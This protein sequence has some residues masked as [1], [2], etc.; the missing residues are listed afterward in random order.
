MRV[1][2]LILAA[3]LAIAGLVAAS[4]GGGG[5]D[6]TSMGGMDMSGATP[7]MASGADGSTEMVT[8]SNWAVEPSSKTLTA[9]KI[10]FMAT[11]AMDHSAANMTGQ[12]GATH[13]LLVAP[14]PA[15]AKAGQSKF[16]APVVNL[17]DIKPGESKT[18]QV[19][20]AAG[21]Y[22]LACLVVEQVNGQ[23]VNHYEKGMFTQVTVN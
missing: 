13:Q 19:E 11:H 3:T 6:N 2:I 10:T 23:T 17:T 7:T 15:G 22:E 5:D 9:G 12:E 14:L 21:T 8:L 4:C 18:A 20:L 16:G 1:R